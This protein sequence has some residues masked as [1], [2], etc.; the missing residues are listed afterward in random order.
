VSGNVTFRNSFGYLNAEL[1][2]LLNFYISMTIIYLI[3]GSVWGYLLKRYNEYLITM[4]HFITLLLI[5][6]FIESVFMYFE[7]YIYNVKGQ[8]SFS[9]IVAN[10]LMLAIRTTISLVLTLLFSLGYGIVTP[11]VKKYMP[12]IAMLAFIYF[13][14]NCI[15]WT[16]VYINHNTPL[17]KSIILIISLPISIA[18]SIFSYW[19]LF[20]LR[21]TVSILK[22]TN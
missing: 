8:R 3:L 11:D 6:G 14:S 17:S 20:S 13:V 22:E 1:Y 10:I 9:F 12:K 5:L 18:N 7:Y 19:I 2:P 15:Y 4:H 16:V 21:R